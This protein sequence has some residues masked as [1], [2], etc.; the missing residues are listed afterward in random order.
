MHLSNRDRYLHDLV[1]VVTTSNTTHAKTAACKGV[2]LWATW[3][4][5]GVDCLMHAIMWI[6]FWIFFNL[7]RGFFD[8]WLF[9]ASLESAGSSAPIEMDH[10]CMYV[11]PALL[12]V[13]PLAVAFAVA[14]AVAG[15]FAFAVAVAFAFALAVAFALA[16]AVAC[17]YANMPSQSQ[18]VFQFHPACMHAWISS[19][20]F[21]GFFPVTR[22]AFLCPVGKGMRVSGFRVCV[23]RGAGEA[24]GGVAVFVAV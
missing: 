4:C 12:T 6:F 17:M 1:V 2:P 11:Y 20:P 24:V 14:V 13:I 21:W 10:R 9:S 18:R 8:C 22:L 5:G 3:E 19:S 7:P 15:A 16:L 23:G